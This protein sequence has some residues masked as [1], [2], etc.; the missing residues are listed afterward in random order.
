[1]K[2][3]S[4]GQSDYTITLDL[5]APTV[6]SHDTAIAVSIVG[7]DLTIAG[8]QDKKTY[9]FSLDSEGTTY[10][11]AV[12][13]DYNLSTDAFPEGSFERLVGSIQAGASAIGQANFA[14]S[15]DVDLSDATVT[16]TVVDNQGT[17]YAAGESF[18]FYVTST[19]YGNN[20]KA[21]CVVW[22]PSTIAPSTFQTSYQILYRLNTP[23]GIQ[24][25][26]ESLSVLGL[27]DFPLG[28][29]D[30]VELLGDNASCT[31]VLPAR[32]NNVSASLFY[33]NTELTDLTIDVDDPIQTNTGFMYTCSFVSTGLTA[34]LEP[35]SLVW[36]YEQNT[37]VFRETSR[38]WLITPSIM[39]AI[40][41]AQSMVM[42]A[43]T[44]INGA[45]DTLFDPTTVLTWL[46]Q[47]RDLFNGS[48]ANTWFDMTNATGA[49]RMFWLRATEI[50]ALR[51]QALA[52]GEKA[53]N[54]QGSSISLEVDR[55]TIYNQL[56][57]SLQQQYDADI[58]PFKQQIAIR[59]FIRGDGDYV[60]FGSQPFRT[61]QGS[62]GITRTP[63][64]YWGGAFTWPGPSSNP[65]S[66]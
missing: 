7:T 66:Q 63:I 10:E 4:K 35:Y 57:D 32:F 5:V 28:T 8:G 22:V 47:G 62:L 31:I 58:K 18:D 13:V 61:R 1:M 23:T 21:Q 46:Q 26:A 53:F 48:A 41:E 29:Q 38:V 39:R 43:R 27:V 45:P 54:F 6:I 51:S 34:S 60:G 42:K 44:T 2:L 33:G 56:A 49:V 11:Y 55:A 30:A 16:W 17:Q 50:L 19:P 15:A 24:L 52:E 9:H 20:I 3:L 37:Q 12:W 40:P 64:N 65:N 59:N 36:K 25:L 14:V